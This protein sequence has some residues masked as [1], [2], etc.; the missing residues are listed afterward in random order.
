[1][2]T[3]QGGTLAHALENGRKLLGV[4]P[5]LAEEQAR[6]ILKSIPGHPMATLLLA[7]AR[8]AQG[9]DAGARAILEPLA[10]AHPRFGAGAIRTGIGAWRAGREPRGDFGPRARRAARPEQSGDLARAWRS[11]HA[12]R[13]RRESRRCL[14]AQHQGVGQRSGA[15]E[16]G[17]GAVREP[18]GRGGAAAARF[19]ESPSDRCRRDA[20]A[21][22]NRLAA[23]R[24]RRRG[25]ASGALHWNW[26]P[27]SPP[28]GTTTPS[29]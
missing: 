15:A 29:C 14:C 4:K 5:A 9:D 16:R 28:R 23:R 7:S 6:E 11:V 20:H 17:D 19:P 24:L 3:Q 25:E 18:A 26:R 22:G 2:S 27:A 13:R 1:M 8:R 21:G 12:R 10:R